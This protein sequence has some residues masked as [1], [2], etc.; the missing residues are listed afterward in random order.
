[1][2]KI[3]LNG[4]LCTIPKISVI[5]IDGGTISTCKFT[6]AVCE[7]VLE[8]II[9]EEAA[10]GID[11]DYFECIAFDRAARSISSNFVKGSKIFLTGKAKN[12]VFQDSNNT[13][14]CTYV[15]LV[16]AAESGDAFS[17]LSQQ[18]VHNKSLDLSIASDLKRADQKFKSMCEKGFLCINEDDYYNIAHDIFRRG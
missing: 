10:S 4:R 18:I 8:E 17:T 14:H 7:N 12:F 2:N 6:V 15:V 5:P 1:M 11:F 3:I 13:L 9:D 16:D